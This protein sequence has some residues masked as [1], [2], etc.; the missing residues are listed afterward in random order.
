MSHYEKASYDL[1]NAPPIPL[2]PESD[3]P[4]SIKQ[5]K[6]LQYKTDL[7]QELTGELTRKALGGQLDV[8]LCHGRHRFLS[9]AALQ[10]TLIAV[11][12]PALTRSRCRCHGHR[13]YCV[14]VNLKND[15]FVL[16]KYNFSSCKEN[17]LTEFMV[18]P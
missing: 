5:S 16:K 3:R 9:R 2:S 14:D 6:C 18:S 17:I 8:A 11:Q 12:S 10:V 4:T 15:I 1:F 7:S 13:R